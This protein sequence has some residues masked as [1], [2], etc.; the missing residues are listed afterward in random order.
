[1]SIGPV[2]SA[3]APEPQ[4]PARPVRPAPTTSSNSEAQPKRE[5]PPPENAVLVPLA[6]Q[7]EV[8]VQWDTPTDYIEIYRFV[9]PESGGLVLQ[10]PSQQM[11]N[12]IHEIQQVLQNTSRIPTVPPT[13]AA[14]TVAEGGK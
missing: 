8:R 5:T 2:S 14:K 3:P 1:M 4:S 7:D 11:L 13:A 9:N 12:L 10:E 6:V